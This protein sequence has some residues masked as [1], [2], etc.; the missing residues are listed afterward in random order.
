M[1]STIS[2][3]LHLC[4]T[5]AVGSSKYHA[6]D[7]ACKERQDTTAGAGVFPFKSVDVELNPPFK[8]QITATSGLSLGHLFYRTLLYSFVPVSPS[9]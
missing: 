1:S 8:Q 4:N 9:Q 3:G 2:H 6:R 7:G 5:N